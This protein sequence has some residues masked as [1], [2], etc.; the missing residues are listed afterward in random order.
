MLH[1]IFRIKPASVS[2]QIDPEQ[3]R[4]SEAADKT[5]LAHRQGLRQTVQKLE[6]GTR[7]M[8]TMSGAMGMMRGLEGG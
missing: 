3:E 6:S 4:L 2:E 5:L 1:R 8:R 7:V